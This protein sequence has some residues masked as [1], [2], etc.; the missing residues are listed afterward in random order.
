MIA[1]S[2]NIPKTVVLRILQEDFFSRDFFLLH[3]NAPAHKA[4]SVCRFLTPKNFTTF[5]HPPY[6]P[7]LSPTNYF[8]FS[9]LKMKLKGLKFSDAAEI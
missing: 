2:L 4:A 5:H 1:G 7:D 3:E 8:L 9:K 6:S